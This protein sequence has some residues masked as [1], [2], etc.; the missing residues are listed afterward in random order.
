M[1]AVRNILIVEDDELIA[2]NIESGLKR[3]GLAIAGIAGDLQSSVN[4]MKKKKVDLAVIDIEL[5]GPE[6]GIDTAIELNKIKWI[7]VIY[8]TGN[9]PLEIKDKLL[10][11]FP[12]AFL[13]KP[14]SI[15]ELFVQIGLALNNFYSGNIPNSN[16]IDS[17]H[18]F[19]PT[20][21]G[22]IGVKVKEI[23]FIQAE[24]IN[25]LLYLT[26]NEHSR[27]FPGSRYEPVLVSTNKGSI[28]SI[29]PLHFYQLS[30][31][32]VINLEQLYRFDSTRIFVH[33]FEIPI[34]EGKRKEL[35]NRLLMVK[36]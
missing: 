36:S 26:E 33:T 18:V 1:E 31:S 17:E 32:Y 27:L 13:E 15:R 23:L 5:S 35:M 21:K 2:A 6:D 9:K 16:Q 20:Y 24:R 25:S 3:E 30:R 11:T 34:P 7:P 19:L 4:I 10:K 14:L 22:F 29:L 8:I 12:A 28:F